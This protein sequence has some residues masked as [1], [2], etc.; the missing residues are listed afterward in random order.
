MKTV[1]TITFSLLL[2]AMVTTAHAGD[3]K[4]S[5]LRCGLKL[6]STPSVDKAYTAARMNRGF[7]AEPAI[8]SFD[9]IAPGF[10]KIK[11]VV[12]KP[13]GRRRLPPAFTLARFE[14]SWH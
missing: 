6:G 11:G 1:K 13:A 8:K 5:L 14:C 7:R 10:H 2:A 9:S 3:A 12:S 4:F